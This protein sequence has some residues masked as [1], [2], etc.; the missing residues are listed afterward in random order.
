M[1]ETVVK[2]QF[3]KTVTIRSYHISEEQAL[4]DAENFATQ[5]IDDMWN[6]LSV[7]LDDFQIIEC[8]T[9]QKEV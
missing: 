4:K 8:K 7:E 9:E 5:Y 1:S 6:Y 2:I 3:V